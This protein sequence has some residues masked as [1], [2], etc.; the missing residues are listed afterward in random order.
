MQLTHY[1]TCV[2]LTLWCPLGFSDFCRKK[3]QFLVTNALA[4][5]PIALE[6]FNDSNGLASLVDCTR[7]NFFC[8]GVRVFCE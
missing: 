2:F 3:Q 1:L 8:L 6:L 7:K 4:P 5:L